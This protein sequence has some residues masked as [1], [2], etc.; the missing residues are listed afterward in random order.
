MS[1]K[2]EWAKFAMPCDKDRRMLY[3]RVLLREE[4]RHEQKR[5]LVGD[6]LILNG[7]QRRFA[8]RWSSGLQTAKGGSFYLHTNGAASFSGSLYPPIPFDLIEATNETLL[9]PFW[10]FHQNDWRAHNG[11]DFRVECPVWRVI[12]EDQ[13]AEV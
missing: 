11:I 9:V 5:A 7:E 10:F 13:A 8:F 1:L 4:L 12:H 2:T 3:D 6:P